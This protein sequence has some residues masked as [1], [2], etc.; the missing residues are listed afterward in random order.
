MDMNS[1]HGHSTMVFGPLTNG[2]IATER[3]LHA[4][5]FLSKLKQNRE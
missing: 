4:F 3:S 2:T 1:D 5:Q